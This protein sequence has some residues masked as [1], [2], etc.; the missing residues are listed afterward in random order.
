[1]QHTFLISLTL[2][3]PFSDKALTAISTTDFCNCP[4]HLNFK[5]LEKKLRFSYVFEFTHLSKILILFISFFFRNISSIFLLLIP[6]KT[7]I[8]YLALYRCFELLGFSGYS[9]LIRPLSTNVFLIQGFSPISSSS[10]IADIGL[11]R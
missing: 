6:P 5:F 1:M 4:S 3:K 11:S 9:S 7:V 10:S 2:K 8:I